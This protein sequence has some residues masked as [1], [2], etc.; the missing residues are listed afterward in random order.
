[1]AVSGVS[2][3]AIPPSGLKARAIEFP[4][5]CFFLEN[6]RSQFLSLRHLPADCPLSL[7]GAADNRRSPHDHQAALRTVGLRYNP[8]LGSPLTR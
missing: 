8:I 6:V 2:L 1:M 7:A 5:I 4:G 3:T